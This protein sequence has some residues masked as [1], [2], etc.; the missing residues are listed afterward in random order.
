MRIERKAMK[1]WF[2]AFGRAGVGAHL[3]GRKTPFKRWECRY[4]REVTL[5]FSPV[6]IIMNQTVFHVAISLGGV[7]DE[8]HLSTE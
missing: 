2:L 1:R 7:I 4:A 3:S 8:T 6:Q 5:T